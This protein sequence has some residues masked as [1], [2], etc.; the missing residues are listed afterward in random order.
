M[1]RLLFVTIGLGAW[2]ATP[3][4][5]ADKAAEVE[6]ERA[7]FRGTWQ[8]VSAVS[9]GVKTPDDVAA[10]VRVVIA[11]SK[12]SV[13]L[14]D[15]VL[16]HDVGWEIDPTTEPRSTTDTINDGPDKGKRIRGIY[17]LEGDTLTSCVGPIDGPRPVEFAAKAG[18]GQTL[19]V[20]RRVK[21]D[22]AKA[23]AIQA[24]HKRFEGTWK[25]VSMEIA[26]KVIPEA[27]MKDSR[28]V[29]E[30]DR[31]RSLGREEAPGRYAIDP[32]AR[33]K[34]IDIAVEVGPGR[35]MKILGIYELEGDTYRICSAMPGKPRPTEFSAKAGSAQG[36][37]VMSRVKP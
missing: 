19:R 29:F 10:K 14:G 37:T 24:E 27:D 25:F 4:L 1:A 22:A 12:H 21:D 36:L 2:L 17:R 34:T 23:E 32:T 30:A 9:D 11:G 3:A 8:L 5:A 13:Y 26:G 20:F 28:L 16:A 6:A 15:K 33:P 31:F 7:R 18:S 35:T